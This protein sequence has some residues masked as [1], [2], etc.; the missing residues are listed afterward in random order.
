MSVD[1]IPTPKQVFTLKHSRKI[2]EE[3][4]KYICEKLPTYNF[5]SQNDTLNSIRIE[6]V[7]AFQKQH[8]DFRFQDTDEN[9]CVFELEVSKFTG[10]MTNG[11]SILKAKKNMD[12]FMEYLTKCIGGY[13]IT[14]EDIKKLKDAKN[15]N[16]L[17]YMIILVIFAFVWYKFLGG[18][19]LLNH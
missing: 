3:K 18:E 8:L 19:F 13:E 16:M 5:L 6:A 2:V 15:K 9:T 10:G 12:E 11:D 17:F 4:I 1:A 7:G 14:E